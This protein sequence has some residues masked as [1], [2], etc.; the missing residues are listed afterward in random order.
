MTSEHTKQQTEKYFEENNF[1]GLDKENVV[2][3][4]QFLLP[5]MTFDGKIIKSAKDKLALSPGY[6]PSIFLFFLK[7]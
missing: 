3:F 4:E 1:F 2:I 5:S 7:S 6:Y